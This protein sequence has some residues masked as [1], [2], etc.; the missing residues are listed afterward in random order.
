MRKPSESN[1]ASSLLAL[2]GFDRV[3][4]PVCCFA[5]FLLAGCATVYQPENLPI[6]KVD[7]QHGYRLFNTRRGDYGDHLVFLAFSG[8]GTRAAAL[9]YGA[10]T[11]LRDTAIGSRGRRVRLLDEV[12]SIS[13]VS[14]G[15]FT[16]AYYGLFGEKIF[17]DFEDGFLRQSIQGALVAGLFSPAYWWRALFTQF[18]RTE[19]AIEFYDQEIFH[20][21]RFSDID[22][23]HGPFIEINATEL[24]SGNRF[25]FTQ[26]HFDAICSNVGEYPVARAVTASSAVPVVFSPVVLKNHAGECDTHR[27]QLV[28]YLDTQAMASPRLEELKSRLALYS[29]RK[30]MPYLQLVDGGISDNLGLRSI[31][32]RIESIGSGFLFAKKSQIPK[33]IL[34]ISVDAQ[35]K[36][37][38]GINQSPN[39]P[40]IVDTID[41]FSN[42][43]LGLY[44]RETKFLLKKQL[45]TLQG[46][47]LAKGYD[48]PVY[49]AE[50]SFESIRLK[51]LRSYLNGLP[52][53]LELSG[54]D[55]DILINTGRKLLRLQP[56]FREFLKMNGATPQ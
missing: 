21:K 41:A 19:M 7:N 16:A 22:L 9:A 39:K 18:D 55:V 53:S 37:E 33:D 14:G 27:N 29:D 32:D 47:L 46:K 12:D 1:A 26:T 43:Q 28:R 20:G 40:S 4:T 23:A 51:S 48:V 34:I 6:A 44:N 36:P 35:I 13:A 45:E 11:A 30:A 52:T 54:R 31:S 10:L 25:S 42:V 17:T 50:V 49:M 38:R 5:L 3:L 24:G 15:G 8:G 56:G 2:L